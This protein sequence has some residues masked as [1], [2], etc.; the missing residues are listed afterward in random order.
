MTTRSQTTKQQSAGGTYPD[1]PRTSITPRDQ[2]KAKRQL[3]RVDRRELRTPCEKDVD[4]K[5]TSVVTLTYSP[6]VN[7]LEH[8]KATRPTHSKQVACQSHQSEDKADRQPH[9]CRRSESRGAIGACNSEANSSKKI[10][11]I[12]EAGC[13]IQRSNGLGGIVTAV[14]HVRQSGVEDDWMNFQVRHVSCYCN[15]PL[16][17]RACLPT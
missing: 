6:R 13:A 17:A 5:N 4:N 7:K 8:N 12:G 1:T 9:Q 15:F 2:R 16:A 10:K 3:Q 14:T 11:R